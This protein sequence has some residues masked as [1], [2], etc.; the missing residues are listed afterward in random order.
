VAGELDARLVQI[1]MSARLCHKEEIMSDNPDDAILKIMAKAALGIVIAPFVY[2][3][4]KVV[5]LAQWISA[6]G[7]RK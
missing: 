7:M 4:L 1:V 5:E 3:A 6:K 2:A